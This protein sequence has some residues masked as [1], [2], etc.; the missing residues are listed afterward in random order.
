MKY[1]LVVG[2][3]CD[4]Y[5]QEPRARIFVGDKLIDEFLIQHHIDTLDTA[6]KFYS[7]YTTLQ[8]YQDFEILNMRLKNFPPLRFYEIEIGTTLDRVELRI[9]IEN[10]DSNNTNGFI[11]QSTLIQLQVLNF[12]PLHQK[13]LSRLNEIKNKNRPTQKYAWYRAHKNSMFDLI[14]NGLCWQGKN[15]Q[16]FDSKRIQL[17]FHK[18]GGDG[19]YTCELVKK[20]QIL[21]NKIKKSSRYYF[22]YILIDYFIDKYQQHAHQRNSH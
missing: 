1:L 7:N 2:F 15:A 22:D 6:K 12:F 16:I 9:E 18:I 20:Y 4:V 8:P 19:V 21:T 10:S 14:R 3:S 17:E 5:R 11:T 13:L